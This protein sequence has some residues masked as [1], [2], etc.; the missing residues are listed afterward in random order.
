MTF[1][2]RTTK[3]PVPLEHCLFY[4]GE[5][6]KVCENEEFLPQGFKAAKDVHKKKT[7]SSVSGGTSLHPGSSTAA[8]K[9]RGQR[10]D[11]SSQG[12]Q[13]KHS[14]PQKSGNFGTGW[15][16]QSNGFGQNN[17][18]LRRSEASLWLT[19]INKLLK[20]SLLPVCKKLSFFNMHGS[21]YIFLPQ[22][23]HGIVSITFSM[24]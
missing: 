21:L 8:D 2:I 12:K 4:S 10:R 1:S 23:V 22:P 7:T 13:H 20:K 11:S 19:L 24:S 14:G 3:R 18:G 16:T 5:L 9:A 6:Y 17:M 15:G